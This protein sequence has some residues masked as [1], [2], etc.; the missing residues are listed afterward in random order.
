MTRTVSLAQ[1]EGPLDLLLALV[2]QNQF[3]ILNL[4]IAEI[5]RQ[6]LDYLSAAKEC[7]LDL[8][9]EWIYTASLLIHI[10]SRSL[11]PRDAEEAQ[12]GTRDE[13][14]RQLLDRQQ[15][16]GA[17]AFLET[18]WSAL[19]GWPAPPPPDPPA[20]EETPGFSGSMTLLEVLQL[21]QHAMAAVTASHQ[22]EIPPDPVPIEQM[23]AVLNRELGGVPPGSRLD[24][25]RVWA[26]APTAQHRSSLFLALLE[27]AR[28]QS[29][30]L[31]QAEPFAPIWIRPAYDTVR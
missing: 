13:L 25:S 3:D 14:V 29:L 4:P 26:S 12:T 18:Q 7:D 30:D 31:E 15:L 1:Y 22:V 6:Y 23:A 9:S 28:S 5:T 17:A 24:F 2:R 20:M 10:K 16:S 8:D 27:G 21:A 11:L 19:G